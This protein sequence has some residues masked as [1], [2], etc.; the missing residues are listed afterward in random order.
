MQ[1]Q[2]PLRSASQ[3]SAASAQL[4]VSLSPARVSSAEEA[5]PDA[6][7]PLR[8]SVRIPSGKGVTGESL[9]TSVEQAYA[10]RFAG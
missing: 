2:G 6:K 5:P 10:D 4:D 3:R 1:Q 8:V 9:P 7:G